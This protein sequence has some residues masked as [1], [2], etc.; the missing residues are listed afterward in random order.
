MNVVAI[1][2]AA[3]FLGVQNFGMFSSVLAIVGI[4][5]K[6]VDFGI[7]PIVF[8]E[9]SK[10][11]ENFHLFSSALSLRFVLFFILVI[12]FNIVSPFLKYSSNEI[13]LT[14]IL[15][16]TIVISMKT[17][18]V[19]DLLAT[20]FKVNLKMHYPMTLAILDNLILLVMVFY[21]PFS[22][23]A[24][25]YFAI[26][27][28]ISNL[29]GFVLSFH[30]LKKKLGY[31]FEA[32]LHR[33]LWLLKE[34]LPLFGFAILTT[35]FMQIDIVILN[36]YK[37]AYDVGIYSAGIRLTMPL[38]IIPGAIVTTVFPILVKRMSDQ[39]SSDF[40]SNK[41]VK[42]LYFIAFVIAAV[43]TFEASALSKIVFGPEYAQTALPSSVLYWCQIFLFFTHYTLAV[44]VAKNKQVYNFLTGA[45]QVV[46]NL[47]F[48][49]LLIP[50]YSFLGAAYAK[51]FASFASFAFLVFILNKFG[52]RPSIGRYKVLIWS[53]FMCLGLYALSILPVV[54]YLIL[55]PLMIGLITFGLRFF[56]KEEL[57]TFF[58]LLNREE[59]GK[60]VIEK[61]KLA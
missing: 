58:R 51:L 15:F 30:Y 47:A 44:L 48:N 20:P 25:I 8:R 41:V 32:T 5:S 59:F 56:N 29:P 16:T 21:I 3:R 23:N 31:K 18:N 13:L 24:L 36:Y 33:S 22:K 7:E 1:V 57:I 34:S 11:K 9:F 43:F 54:P 40:L 61:Y 45:I 19:R 10:D 60:R 42:L 49:F 4:L 50:E 14:N 26:A 27:Y 35:I 12:T 53:I 6:F 2:L 55:S 17:V 38:N 46:V 37:G 28:S 39:A 52:Y